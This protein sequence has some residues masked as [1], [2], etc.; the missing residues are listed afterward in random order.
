M[1]IVALTANALAGVGNGA[2][3]AGM[4]AYLTKPVLLHVLEEALQRWLPPAAPTAPPQALDIGVLQSLVGDDACVLR[5]FLTEYRTCA[6]QDAA[7]LRAAAAAGDGLRVS[8]IA[9]RLKSSSRSVGALALGELCAALEDA[10]QDGCVPPA[11]QALMQF[12]QELAAVD[13]CIAS[14]LTRPLS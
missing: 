5:D 4:D 12:D 1:P 6:Q 10:G 13:A 3:A 9:H 14:A 7:A 11:A 2:L 8:G